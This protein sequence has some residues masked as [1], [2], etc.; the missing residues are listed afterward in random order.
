MVAV[1]VV[2]G[3]GS[4]ALG[5]IISTQCPDTA[6]GIPACYAPAPAL[7]ATS[8]LEQLVQLA[9][10]GQRVLRH[11]VDVRPPRD[12]AGPRL[13]F[14]PCGVHVQRAGRAQ[15]RGGLGGRY[16]VVGAH[17]ARQLER[18]AVAVLCRGR[19][20]VGRMGRLRERQEECLQTHV[21]TPYIAN[22]AKPFQTSP[23]TAPAHPRTHP[24]CLRSAARGCR[25]AG[26]RCPAWVT[27]AARPWGWSAAAPCTLRCWSRGPTSS[28]DGQ[29][30]WVG[31]G[32]AEE[33][34]TWRCVE[35]V[36][37][38]RSSRQISRLSRNTST[39]A[40]QTRD[41][42]KTAVQ[43]RLPVRTAPA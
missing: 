6:P 19:G 42:I 23:A 29:G 10:Q 34:G 37:C 33:S 32:G 15:R 35:Q 18:G 17:A 2:Q 21:G 16:A 41:E 36:E 1:G 31:G 3:P 38:H 13:R 7:A 39:R 40:Q 9:Q 5:L 25:A 30:G 43:R 20:R 28:V 11:G 14:R 24:S 27:W 12:V 8:H 22:Y 26:R 4:N